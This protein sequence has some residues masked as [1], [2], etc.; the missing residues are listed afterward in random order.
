[1]PTVLGQHTK[2]ALGFEDMV[3]Q[4]VI[5]IAL[6]TSTVT[7]ALSILRRRPIKVDRRRV[8]FLGFSDVLNAVATMTNHSSNSTAHWFRHD[9][10]VVGCDRVATQNSYVCIKIGKL[11]EVTR[12]SVTRALPDKYNRQLTSEGGARIHCMHA[13]VGE[14]ICIALFFCYKFK[15]LNN[16]EKPSTT[17]N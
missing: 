8:Y 9:E 6:W 15:I 3:V 5:T 17:G 1:M 11:F 12:R 7:E 13:C 10:I 2:S 14:L 4:Q 16:K